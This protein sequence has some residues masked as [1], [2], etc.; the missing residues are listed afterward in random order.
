M[1]GHTGL[2]WAARNDQRDVA[3]L[4]LQC[5]ASANACLGGSDDTEE[6]ERNDSTALHTAARNGHEKL[7]R[8][9]LEA[10]ADVT[11]VDRKLHIHPLAH[12]CTARPPIRRCQGPAGA[13]SRPRGS[14]ELLKHFCVVLWEAC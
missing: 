6:E 1:L 8:L 12:A 2:H 9:L 14:P 4:L 13:S 3:A 11:L 10:G 7:C 5:G